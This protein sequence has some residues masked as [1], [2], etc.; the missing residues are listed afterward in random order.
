MLH[1]KGWEASAAGS[2]LPVP[3]V[4]LPGAA[5]PAVGTAAD[6]ADDDGAEAEGEAA[7]EPLVVVV[8]PAV[9]V[10]VK[11]PSMG[12]ESLLTTRQTTV[13]SP[14]GAPSRSFWTAWLSMI[15]TGP[16]AQFS[17]P[18]VTVTPEP[19]ASGRLL[20]VMETDAGTSVTLVPLAGVVDSATSWADAGAAENS[21]ADAKARAATTAARS[22]RMVRMGRF[23]LVLAS[24]QTR[25]IVRSARTG[26]HRI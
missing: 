24:L 7:A 21:R 12:C 17:P 25:R 14:A 4:A 10:K 15:S 18:A 2:L 26:P 3:C 8:L 13:Y 11:V 5:V 16:S 6:G 1:G 19:M 23:L 20:N 22:G 9:A